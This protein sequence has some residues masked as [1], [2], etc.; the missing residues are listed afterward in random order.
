[1]KS[2]VLGRMDTYNST[3]SGEI[4]SQSEKTFKKVQRV[5]G[6]GGGGTSRGRDEGEGRAGGGTRG[7]D[8]TRVRKAK[9]RHSIW[10]G[11]QRVETGMQRV[12]EAALIESMLLQPDI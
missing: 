8:A 4:S 2:I 7:R 5:G 1:M 12:A 9:C 6:G 11:M 10:G 3:M